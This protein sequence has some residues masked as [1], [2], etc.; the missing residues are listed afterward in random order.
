MPTKQK[1][2]IENQYLRKI[3]R[4][5]QLQIKKVS[6]FS[7]KFQSFSISKCNNNSN[8]TEKVI[9][10]PLDS[11]ADKEHKFVYSCT[12]RHVHVHVQ[13]RHPRPFVQILLTFQGAC[14]AKKS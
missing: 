13:N 14:T 8:N 2:S 1:F 4:K 12:T 9:F 6:S 11:C 5:N 10:V 3:E 7:I